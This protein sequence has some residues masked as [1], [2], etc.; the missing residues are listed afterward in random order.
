MPHLPS[1]HK[2]FLPR[3]ALIGVNTLLSDNSFKPTHWYLFFP[4]HDSFFNPSAFW[5]DLYTVVTTPGV[6]ESED[7][8]RQKDVSGKK[9]CVRQKYS[10]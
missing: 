6:K 7:W 8:G 5:S 3:A 4:S 1:S 9:F 2:V 10:S